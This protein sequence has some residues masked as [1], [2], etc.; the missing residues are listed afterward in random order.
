VIGGLTAAT[1]ATLL[2]VPM[3]YA[4]AQQ[5]ASRRSASLNPLDDRS[6]LYDAR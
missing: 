3:L 1:A 2:I 5:R 4:A 6:A